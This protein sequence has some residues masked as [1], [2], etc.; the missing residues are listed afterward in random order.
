MKNILLTG[1]IIGF[2]VVTLLPLAQINLFIYSFAIFYDFLK[3][4]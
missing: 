4:L 2:N 3:V 1:G